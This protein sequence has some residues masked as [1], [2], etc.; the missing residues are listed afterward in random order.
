MF[1]AHI[2]KLDAMMQYMKTV[3]IILVNALLIVIAILFYSWQTQPIIA[4]TENGFEFTTKLIITIFILT[5]ILMF[6][7]KGLRKYG[8]GVSSVIGSLVIFSIF[9]L[10]KAS[11]KENYIRY[12]QKGVLTV[13]DKDISY[14]NTIY[15]GDKKL[16]NKVDVNRCFEFDSIDIKVIEGQFGFKYFTEETIISQG[17]NCSEKISNS[18]TDPYFYGIKLIKRRCFD[19]AKEHY[20]KLITLE[21]NNDEWFYYRGLV[22]L[23]TDEYK[24]AL[25]DF[26]LGA[27][28]KY[29]QI[30]N[31]KNIYVNKLI[32]DLLEKFKNKKFDNSI[33]KDIIALDEIGQSSDYLERIRYCI[34]KLKSV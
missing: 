34:I 21:S 8:L 11:K 5:A 15:L 30:E 14:F 20:S 1:I 32:N 9:N 3:I 19:Q 24:L 31:S 23:F 6:F 12:R 4:R 28:I 2:F 18:K 27:T 10:N 25:S 17:M 26:L 13:Y 7:I 29:S 22:Y 33:V 16:R